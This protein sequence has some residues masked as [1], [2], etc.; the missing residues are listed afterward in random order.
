MVAVGAAAVWGASCGG[1]A[2]RP[3]DGGA[4]G[5]DGGRPDRGSPDAPCPTLG[6][7][8]GE[9]A[10]QEVSLDGGVPL[11]QIIMPSPSHVAVT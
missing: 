4:A 11:G 3:R 2:E 7:L 8:V 1:G 10:L 9:P 6:T 5:R